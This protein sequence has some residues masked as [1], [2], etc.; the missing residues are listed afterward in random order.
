MHP[1]QPWEDTIHLLSGGQV[2]RAPRPGEVFELPEREA[3]RSVTVMLICTVWR[4]FTFKRAA[5]MRRGDAPEPLA[6][7]MKLN[8]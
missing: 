3:R 7:N 4:W 2:K 5:Q 1:F 8:C 6:A